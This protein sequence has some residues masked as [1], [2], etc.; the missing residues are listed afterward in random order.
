[1]PDCDPSITGAATS[2][3]IGGV[4]TGYDTTAT[5]GTTSAVRSSVHPVVDSGIMA[6]TG[7]SATAKGITPL[8]L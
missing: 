6:V 7:C 8:V 1:M 4:M 2:T 5:V 3:C